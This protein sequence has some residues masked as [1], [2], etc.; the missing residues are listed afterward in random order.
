MPTMRLITNAATIMD[1]LLGRLAP[2]RIVTV[3]TPDYTVTPQGAAYGD[4]ATQ[5]AA[6]ASVQSRVSAG[7]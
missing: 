5:A 2:D 1:D 4:P 6:L 7:V 3:A